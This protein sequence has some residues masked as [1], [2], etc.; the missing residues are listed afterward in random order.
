MHTYNMIAHDVICIPVHW[1]I[2][3]NTIV[4]IMLLECIEIYL[5]NKYMLQ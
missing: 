2:G 4:H 5:V 3:R 1:I